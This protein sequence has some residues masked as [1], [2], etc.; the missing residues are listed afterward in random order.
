MGT[1]A[2]AII[3]F[4]PIS[5]T[6]ETLT[7][8]SV[9]DNVKKH[10]ARFEPL[11][12]YLAEGLAD[13][14]I[15]EVEIRV[16]PSSDE[17]IGA[18]REGEVDLF[19]DSPLVATNVADQSGGQPFLRRWKDGVATYHSVIIVPADSQIETID[20]LL[21]HR[22][23]FQEPDSTSGFLLPAAF[24][25][26]A[27]LELQELRSKEATPDEDQI[28][29]VFTHD[30][31]NTVS[32]LHRGWID[33][34]AT[35]PGSFEELDAALPG[36]FRIIARSIEVP[37]QIVVS[38]AALSTEMQAHIAELLVAMHE[39]E[40]GRAVLEQFN[41]TDRFDHFPDGLEQTFEPIREVLAELSLLNLY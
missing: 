41:D 9:S 38:S 14:G 33:A 28:G 3:Q 34:A 23:G 13:V 16:L 15:T 31:K 2:F 17:M 20:D 8:G 26:R 36:Q 25:R 35:D 6:A 1:L 30:D 24:L 18:M 32:W 29:Y 27:D 7:L 11:A 39:S 21:G 4:L 5:A 19:F 40:D 22:I 37:R 12:A 10:L